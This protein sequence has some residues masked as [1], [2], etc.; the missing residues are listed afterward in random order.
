MVKDTFEVVAHVFCVIA[1]LCIP[2]GIAMTTLV[3][4]EDA[5]V[6][7]DGGNEIIP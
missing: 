2:I 3:D 4:G 1:A 7:R 5:V 6:L